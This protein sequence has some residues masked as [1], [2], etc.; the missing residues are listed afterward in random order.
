MMKPLRLVV[1]LLVASLALL[2]TAGWAQQAGGN[3]VV[4]VSTEPPGLDLTASPASAIAAVIHY[5]VQ[6]CLVKVDKHGKIV[7]W[8]A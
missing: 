4:Q 3:L 7:P 6:E 2:P 5:N 8:L 1:A